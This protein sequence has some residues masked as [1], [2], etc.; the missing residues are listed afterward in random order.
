MPEEGEWQGLSGS[1]HSTLHPLP[2]DRGGD[3]G[4]GEVIRFDASVLY[5]TL[6]ARYQTQAL[7]SSS[8]L[9][10]SLA[11]YKIHIIRPIL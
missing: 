2:T 9:T 7:S 4:C 10:F 8:F 5:L 6:L 3:A 1:E 11:S